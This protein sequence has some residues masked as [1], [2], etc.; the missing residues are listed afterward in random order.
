MRLAVPLI[1]LIML[2]G[3]YA[4]AQGTADYPVRPVTVIVSTAPGGPVDFEARLHTTKLASF[5]GQSFILDHKPGAGTTIGAG[6]AAKAK[7]DGYTLVA[8][9]G[10]FTIFPA[11]YKDL[12]FDM[13]RDLAPISLMSKRTTV[14][15]VHPS[16]PASSFSQ[17]LDYVR[18]N[19]GKVNYGT[20]AP[21]S[22]SH[23]AG[24]WLHNA[25]NTKVTFVSYKGA[26]PALTDLMSG[27]ID[28]SST[29]LATAMPLIK[30]GKVRALA[31]MNDVRSAVLPALPTVA[32]QGIPGYNYA[33]WFGFGAPAATATGIIN[34]LHE[35][36]VRVAK[37]PDIISTLEKDGGI[38]MGSTPAEFRRLIVREIELWKKIVRD[39][40]IKLPK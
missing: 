33:A 40:G 10:S 13:A 19:P 27:R 9:T 8:L 6:Y 5:L 4:F 15:L 35:G 26:G 1:L 39:N 31:V 23:L 24:S 36:L 14:L 30:A 22:G 7:P 29:A 12:P 38:V 21:G 32:E 20:L 34:R 37:S 11:L 18:A 2:Q 25:S 28:V 16:F 3:G 17:Y